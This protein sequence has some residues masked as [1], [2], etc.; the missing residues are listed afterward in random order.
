MELDM[1]PLDCGKSQAPDACMKCAA[2]VRAPISDRDEWRRAEKAEAAVDKLRRGYAD[3]TA[4]LGSAADVWT[5]VDR[6]KARAEKAENERDE[7]WESANHLRAEVR[8]RDRALGVERDC[9][10]HQYQRAVNA[11]KE[12]DEFRRA[13][14]V[15]AQAIA[16]GE[17]KA[18]LQSAEA[19]RERYREALEAAR[20]KYLTV[21]GKTNVLQ[22]AARFTAHWHADPNFRPAEEGA[23]VESACQALRQALVADLGD[24]FRAA[25]APSKP[26]APES[27]MNRC[28]LPPRGWRC[29]HEAGHEGSCP[30]WPDH[31]WLRLK[32]TVKF[33]DFS[34]LF[35]RHL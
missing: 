9:Y 34:Y 21:L 11:E 35:A 12:R 20:D 10:E 29:N 31:W 32:F 23:R 16:R 3:L 30:T 28:R 15:E 14:T 13:Y 1:M 7:A 18:R 8:D 19:E 4:M 25:L 27:T 33:Q 2:C 17:Y 22:Y 26:T 24:L 5:A 6:L